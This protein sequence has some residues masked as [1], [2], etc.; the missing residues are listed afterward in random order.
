M[1]TKKHN[2][3]FTDYRIFIGLTE[4]AGYYSSLHKGL[5]EIGLKC[6]LYNQFINPFKYQFQNNSI[7]QSVYNYLAPKIENSTDHSKIRR[8]TI[9]I[10]LFINTFIL[11]IFCIF[12][13]NVF[14]FGF[15]SSFFPQFGF[16]DLKILVALKKKVICVF[17]GSDV[18]PPYMDGFML[19][20]NIKH[21]G[22]EIIRLAKK[23]KMDLQKI[24]RYSDIR[25]IHPPTAHF[26]NK[27]FVSFLHLGIPMFVN[28]VI[29]L[30]KK[31]DSDQTIILHSP[32]NLTGKGTHA[33]RKAIIDLK[34][35][36]YNIKY[37]EIS[38]QPNAV[39]LETLKKCDF[40]IDQIY[41][42]AIRLENRYL[43]IY[44][45]SMKLF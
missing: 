20:E 10:L 3:R 14:I 32:S 44:K 1:F 36:G 29:P 41:R 45:I 26:A 4:I 28:S 42:I 8:L 11:F 6:D 24:E 39:V 16:I 7:F 23:Q 33:I 15:K 31:S 9:H 30:E 13:Y 17:N 18:R 37:I 34:E 27:K 35:K 43:S 40:V 12:K 19:S 21:S 25:I 5:N 38:K 2:M 22:S